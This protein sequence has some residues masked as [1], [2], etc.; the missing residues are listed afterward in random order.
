MIKQIVMK[1]L[2]FII[3]C[4]FFVSCN[5]P[6]GGD[7]PV[8]RD[9]IGDPIDPADTAAHRLDPDSVTDDPKMDF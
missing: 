3:A 1:T 9:S 5:Q 7:D 6:A 8:E 2:I 4:I